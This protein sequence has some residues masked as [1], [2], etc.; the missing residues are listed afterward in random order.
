MGDSLAL[1]AVASISIG[2]L[3]G[4]GIVLALLAVV[5]ASDNGLIDK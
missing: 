1:A 3:V 2:F 4:I 5:Y